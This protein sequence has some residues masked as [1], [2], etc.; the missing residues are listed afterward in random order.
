M[1]VCVCVY[2]CAHKRACMCACM[3]VCTRVCFT[4]FEL[5]LIQMNYNQPLLLSSLSF[6]KTITPSVLKYQN[7]VTVTLKY[8]SFT[9]IFCFNSVTDAA[10]LTDNF[11]QADLF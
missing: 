1:C 5:L 4:Y 11:K 9:A 10:L 2:V 6:A 3:R 8:Q 7:V